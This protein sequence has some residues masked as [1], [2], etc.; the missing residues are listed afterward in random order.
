MSSSSS[1]EQRSIA[2]RIGASVR[3]YEERNI[4]L[5]SGGSGGGSQDLGAAA[6]GIDDDDVDQHHHHHAASTRDTMDSRSEEL[7]PLTAKH[8]SG[9]SRRADSSI[10]VDVTELGVQTAGVDGGATAPP[11]PQVSIGSSTVTENALVVLTAYSTML[12][13]YLLA[14]VMVPL[15]MALFVSTLLIPLLDLLTER[16]PRCC[17]RIWCRRGCETCLVLE[18]KHPNCC[19][20][21]VT[22]CLTLRLPAPIGLALVLGLVVGAFIGIGMLVQRSVASF[23]AEV[24]AYEHAL[25]NESQRVLA[26]LDHMAYSPSEEQRHQLLSFF[27]ETTRISAV[28][29]LACYIRNAARASKHH[30]ER[31]LWMGC[32]L[33]LCRFSGSSRDQR[34][35]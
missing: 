19:C 9:F 21:M 34:R 16:P 13:L 14:D 20:T 4:L 33:E 8:R 17:R 1:P 28:V 32:D 23:A 26:A 29:R 35:C 11:A 5:V 2:Q 7:Q 18:K 12:M 25:V 22:S 15:V 24:P 3:T 30:F 31:P 6:V 10:R 27:S